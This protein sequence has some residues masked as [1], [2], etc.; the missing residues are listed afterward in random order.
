MKENRLKKK[1]VMSPNLRKKLKVEETMRKALRM[2]W[3]Q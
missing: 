2:K 3:N 1:L